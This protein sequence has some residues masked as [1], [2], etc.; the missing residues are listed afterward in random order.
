MYTSEFTLDYGFFSIESCIVTDSSP[1]Q[2]SK[3]KFYAPN[4]LC[5][6]SV[7]YMAL[8]MSCFS[9]IIRV[10]IKGSLNFC[11]TLIKKE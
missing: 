10:L 3:L 7:I 9:N 8:N 1:K 2:A 5:A 6:I 11:S 4:T